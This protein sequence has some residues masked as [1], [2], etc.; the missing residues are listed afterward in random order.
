MKSLG[1][2]FCHRASTLGL[3]VLVQV[4]EVF[5]V[6]H[7]IFVLHHLSLSLNLEE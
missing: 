6:V 1:Y 2:N 7:A 3:G 5:Y 4:L